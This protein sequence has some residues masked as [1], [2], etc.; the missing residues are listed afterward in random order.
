MVEPGMAQANLEGVLPH[1]GPAHFL[2]QDLPPAH[3]GLCDIAP[4]CLPGHLLCQLILCHG[5]RVAVP[6]VLGLGHAGDRGP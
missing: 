2:G 1:V 4:G 3:L 6:A 5:R